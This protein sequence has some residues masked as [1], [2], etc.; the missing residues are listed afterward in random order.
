MKITNFSLERDYLTV[1]VSFEGTFKDKNNGTGNFEISKALFDY[2]TK[3]MCI[4]TCYYMQNSCPELVDH[5]ESD[6]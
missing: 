6:L 5:A 3:L 1:K 4:I 2:T